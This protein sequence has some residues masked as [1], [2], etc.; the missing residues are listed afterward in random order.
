M[1]TY[2]VTL[3]FIGLISGTRA[4]A[5]CGLALLLADKLTKDQRKAVGW[6]LFGVGV[7]TTVPLILLLTG[8]GNKHAPE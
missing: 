3:P 2:P 4:I 5:G 8:C 6:A 1:K 7:V